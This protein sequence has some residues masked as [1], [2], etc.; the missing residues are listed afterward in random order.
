M[1]NK[2]TTLMLD[3]ALYS[4]IRKRAAERGTSVSSIV[5]E[6][7]GVYLTHS[8][9]QI[10]SPVKLTVATGGGWIGPPDPLSNRD[11]LD[12]IDEDLHGHS[13]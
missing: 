10:R 5:S 8:D 7:L 2:K 3:E 12:P 6:A 9:R 11:M 1:S 13:G 4:D